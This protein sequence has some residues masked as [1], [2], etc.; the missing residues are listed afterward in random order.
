AELGIAGQTQSPAQARP[1][2]TALDT[3]VAVAGRELPPRAEA[4]VDLGGAVGDE[5]A[6]EFFSGAGLAMPVREA[7]PLR[8]DHLGERADAKRHAKALRGRCRA[9]ARHPAQ[10]GD[11]SGEGGAP[12]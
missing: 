3:M 2:E 1:F 4:G 9:A 11:G 10:G 6:L 8:E 7:D 5:E 12:G